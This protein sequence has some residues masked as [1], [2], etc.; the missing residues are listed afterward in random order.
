[1]VEIIPNIFHHVARL[2]H[3]IIAFGRL[4][5]QPAIFVIVSVIQNSY[6]SH[7]RGFLASITPIL[8]CYAALNSMTRFYLCFI[9]LAV[10]LCTW[11]V[12]D[13]V[14]RSTCCDNTGHSGWSV[15]HCTSQH[16]YLHR[17]SSHAGQQRQ[18]SNQTSGRRQATALPSSATSTT[19]IAL[20][21]ILQRHSR[22]TCST[23][24]PPPPGMFHQ[25]QPIL[26]VPR[27]RL[28]PMAV[29]LSQSLAQR[30]GTVSRISSG[31]RQSALTLSDVC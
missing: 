13:C 5:P 6:F 31:T 24:I 29:G 23:A 20:L 28:S 15:R 18:S 17:V 12:A 2:K 3:E 11:S 7:T 26:A 1:V 4:C 9:P 19:T 10:C 25:P 14:S 27:H 16:L 30:S 21:S 22:N 8:P